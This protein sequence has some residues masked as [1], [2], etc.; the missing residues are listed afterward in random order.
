MCWLLFGCSASVARDTVCVA[1]LSTNLQNNKLHSKYTAQYFYACDN[2]T[3]KLHIFHDTQSENQ[4]KRSF[5]ICTL[6]GKLFRC[7]YKRFLRPIHA[8]S[9]ETKAKSTYFHWQASTESHCG[10][11]MHIKCGMGSIGRHTPSSRASYLQNLNNNMPYEIK[12]IELSVFN[13][14]QCLIDYNSVHIAYWVKF[15]IC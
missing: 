10:A 2:K 15:G 14:K 3:T 13:A 4:Q 12:V 7:V 6:Y 11:G 5:L 9:K 1:T 8:I